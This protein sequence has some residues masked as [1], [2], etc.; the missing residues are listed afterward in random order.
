MKIL[1]NLDQIF[2]FGIE[3]YFEISMFEIYIILK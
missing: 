2:F 3:A 1:G